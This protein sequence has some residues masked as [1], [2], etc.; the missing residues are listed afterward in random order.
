MQILPEHIL[1]KID[2][3]TIR[4]NE[5]SKNPIGSGPFKLKLMQNANDLNM[6]YLE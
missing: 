4:E 5:F 1:G 3:V 2:P 6:D